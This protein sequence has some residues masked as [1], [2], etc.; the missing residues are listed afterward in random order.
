[1]HINILGPLQIRE[2]RGRS[3]VPVTQPLVRHALCVLAI[4]AGELVSSAKLIDLLWDDPEADTRRLRTLMHEVRVFVG[5]RR[6]GPSDGTGYQ[7]DLIGDDSVDLLRFRSLAYQ[8]RVAA[9]QAEPTSSV[10]MLSEAIALWRDTS[11]TDLSETPAAQALTRSL[12]DEL[13]R[14]REALADAWLATGDYD[15]LITAA[16]VWLTDDPIYEVLWARLMLALWRSGRS[17]EALRAFDEAATALQREVRIQPSPILRRMCDLIRDGKDPSAELP[18]TWA[19]ARSE[20]HN[21]M[22]AP[23]Q[24]PPDLADFTGRDDEC[25]ELVQQLDVRREGTATPVLLIIGPPGVGKSSLAVHAAHAVRDDYPD[26]QLYIS[27]RKQTPSL[28]AAADALTQVL[29]SFGVSPAD[30]PETLE[31]RS[32]LYRSYLARRRVLV[33]VDEATGPEQIR[34]LIPGTSGSALIATSR[35]RS[36]Y[37]VGGYLLQL[38][39]MTPNDA[40]RLLAHIVGSAVVDA[41]P[42]ATQTVIEACAG[43]P[44]AVRIAGAKLAARRSWKLGDLARMLTERQRRLDHLT[45]GELAIRSSFDLSYESLP[46]DVA[47]A[48]RLAS[49]IASPHFSEWSMAALIDRRHADDEINV[50]ADRSL[51][52]DCGLD[53]AGQP[54]YAMHDL[55][56]EYARGLA[57]GDSEL[58]QASDRL[59][60]RSLELADLAGAALP[61]ALYFAIPQRFSHEMVEASG[62][63]KQIVTQAARAWFDSERS[64]LTGV[65]RAACDSGSVRVACDLMLRLSPHLLFSGHLH[66]MPEM[67]RAVEHAAARVGDPKVAAAARFY[68]AVVVGAHCGRY[69]EALAMLDQPITSFGGRGE[70]G[71]LAQALAL[72]AWCKQAGNRLE[73]AEADVRRGLRLAGDLD[74]EHAEFANLLSM[75]RIYTLQHR[76]DIAIETCERADS[77]AR[78]QGDWMYT[79]LAKREMVHTLTSAERYPDA[80]DLARRNLAEA[81]AD[82]WKQGLACSTRQYGRALSGLGEYDEALDS[83][84]RAV[85]L[86]EQLGAESPLAACRLDLARVYVQMGQTSKAVKQLDR[87]LAMLR[88]NGM[89]REEEEARSLLDC[90]GSGAS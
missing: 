12:H 72:R 60:R 42:A 39:P 47:R 30:I 11:I 4:Y 52:N 80:V 67:W 76:Y 24:L 54:R 79:S 70:G 7:L 31:G 40:R 89:A 23:A 3:L 34:P 78:L 49:V 44:L 25:S 27:L 77:V 38:G 8:A 61:N 18:P 84:S 9:E 63:T 51:L 41:E 69:M 75:A 10:S 56:L 68:Q 35:T 90:C 17:A 62:R 19:P 58:G 15:A 53:A 88:K 45:A 86:Y 5:E 57:T 64:T 66:D 1:M 32:A 16:R 82:G 71:L 46:G 26:G 2:G 43:L 6:L 48:F 20:G 21:T 50:L 59:A 55:V 87:S 13:A 22:P 65:A 29:R 37:I 36:C 85:Q 74:D 83:L 81:E 14:A 28:Q 73:S 33:V